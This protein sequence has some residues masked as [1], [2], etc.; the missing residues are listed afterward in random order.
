MNEIEQKRKELERGCG[1]CGE[2]IF[3]ITNPDNIKCGTLW[4][5]DYH[6][7]QNC[8]DILAGFNLGVEMARKEFLGILDDESAGLSRKDRFGDSIP[9]KVL[10]GIIRD[11][12]KQLG[13]KDEQKFNTYKY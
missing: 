13:G 6:Y 11:R 3:P 8:M 7:C 5:G 1:G 10:I 2:R 9:F 12:V 4:A